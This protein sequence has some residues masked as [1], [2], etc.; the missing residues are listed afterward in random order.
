M[1]CSCTQ[2]SYWLKFVKTQPRL[3]VQ[4]KA[5]ISDFDSQLGALS[6]K[7]ELKPLNSFLRNHGMFSNSSIVRALIWVWDTLSDWL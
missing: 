3:I 4:G 2:L 1:K 5:R 7:Q 6:L